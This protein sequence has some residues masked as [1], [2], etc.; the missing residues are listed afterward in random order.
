M[1][2]SLGIEKGKPFNPD[3]KT[4]VAWRRARAKPKRGSNA[5]YHA[6]FF[7]RS[8]RDS[9][10]TFLAVPELSMPCKKNFNDPDAYPVDARGL[11]YTY[12]FIGIKRLGRRPVLSDQHQGQEGKPF[13]DAT[14]IA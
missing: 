11:A 7:R 2:R 6:G 3:A 1:L 9:R 14:P 4:R 10:W 13:N 12:A 8:A 5:R